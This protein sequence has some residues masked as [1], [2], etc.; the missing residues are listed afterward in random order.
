MLK[1]LWSL[2]SVIY[3]MEKVTFDTSVIAPF[4]KLLVK[5]VVVRCYLKNVDIHFF[6]K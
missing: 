1:K 3:W 4:K 5:L 2:Y 6:Y